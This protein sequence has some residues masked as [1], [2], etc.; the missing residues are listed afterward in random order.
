MSLTNSQFDAISFIYSERR[1]ANAREQEARRDEVYRRI[2]ELDAIDSEI[3]S[4]SVSAAVSRLTGGEGSSPESLHALIQEKKARRAELLSEYGYPADYLDPIYTCPIC[5]DTGFVNGE[6]CVCFEQESIRLL[7]R[8]S[9]LEEILKT[10]N[11]D[12]FSMSYYSRDFRDP[13]T[14][15]S[16]YDLMA[17]GLGKARKFIDTFDSDFSNLFMYGAT[18]LGKTFLS[19]CI[20]KE[21]LEKNKLVVYFSATDFFETV[22]LR[23]FDRDPDADILYRRALSSDLVI[24]DDLGTEVPNSFLASALFTFLNSRIAGRRSCII[25]TNL[26]LERFREI[27]GE[28]IFSRIMSCY[29]FL[30]FVGEDIRRQKRLDPS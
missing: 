5:R 15:Q 24:L 10:E 6:R 16:S 8:E 1:L 22:S 12:H 19:H 3:S 11:F 25:S 17:D 27:Y 20:A 9:N 7:S 26:P 23:H 14:G 30:S 28:R 4:A 29:V 13:L 2:P 18:G 21:I